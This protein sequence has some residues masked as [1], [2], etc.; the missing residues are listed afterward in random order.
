MGQ[1]VSS[2][3]D[4][5][6]W[7]NSDSSKNNDG[8]TAGARNGSHSS[9]LPAASVPVCA[10]HG[11]P[12]TGDQQNLE[13][14]YVS[15][16]DAPSSSSSDQNVNDGETL[17][18]VSDVETVTSKNTQPSSS[19]STAGS[20]KLNHWVLR[21]NCSRPKAKN[22]KYYN[23][24]EFLPKPN[25]AKCDTCVCTSYNRTEENHHMD[26]GEVSDPSP[27]P[28]KDDLDEIDLD[29]IDLDEAEKSLRD[30]GSAFNAFNAF[31]NRSELVLPSFDDGFIDLAEL[32][33]R[34][35]LNDD[36]ED[37][38]YKER[39]KEIQEGIEPPPGFRPGL[40]IQLVEFSLPKM[41]I[42]NLTSLFQRAAITALT[43]PHDMDDTQRI[44]TS[45]DY[46]HY[47]VPDLLQITNCSFYW[48]KMDRYEAEKLL[49]NKPEGTF[50]LRD[51]AQEEYLFSVSFRKYGRSLHARIE[52]WNHLFSFDSRDP[53]VFASSTVCGLI[54]HYKD[55][56]CCMFFEPMLT[57]P[58]H[59]NFTF[60]LQHT[61][62]AAICSQITYDDVNQ[63]KLPKL[64]KSYLKEYHYKQRVRVRIFDSEN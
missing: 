27:S 45:I 57:I 23:P 10:V 62:R 51:S 22:V 49:E 5:F 20:K 34:E 17:A 41:T 47:L 6:P 30:F 2:L 13:N 50:L 18:T 29:D 15:N 63:L 1:K 36:V 28:L 53:G 54:E 12:V 48:G 19:K 11:V 42:D 40:H 61:C 37:R 60:S 46:I 58:L 43:A 16:N 3:G 64:L 8:L 33:R 9:I 31:E 35:F 39:A 55:P 59:R 24:P 7:K 26:T 32:T 14:I 52:Q 4:V 25:E 44:H 38:A 21:F 56:T